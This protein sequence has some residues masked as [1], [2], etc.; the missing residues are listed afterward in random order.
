MAAYSEKNRYAASRGD[1]ASVDL[2]LVDSR[3]G[4]LQLPG[5]DRD[6]Q[7]LGCRKAFPRELRG[8]VLAEPRVFSEQDLARILVPHGRP[9]GVIPADPDQPDVG[10]TLELRGVP[11]YRFRFHTELGLGPRVQSVALHAQLLEEKVSSEVLIPGFTGED[12]I[13]PGLHSAPG[14]DVSQPLFLLLLVSEGER[15]VGAAVLQLLREPRPRASGG[16]V[17]GHLLP[18]DEPQQL[19]GMAQ[20]PYPTRA[21][22]E[23]RSFH[24]QAP[25]RVRPADGN[26][27]VLPFRDGDRLQDLTGFEAGCAR[28]TFEGPSLVCVFRRSVRR[29]RRVDPPSARIRGAP[30]HVL[31]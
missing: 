12:Q 25:E 8:D 16:T 9:L 19:H 27:K 4:S 3:H 11:V 2:V 24:L 15:Q 26:G 5:M 13:E 29:V 21:H 31:A 6:E 10:R 23:D 14:G 20:A 18:A 1:R 17:Q 28:K 22:M 7:V 30:R